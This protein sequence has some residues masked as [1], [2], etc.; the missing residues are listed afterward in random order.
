MGQTGHVFDLFDRGALQVNGGIIRLGSKG[1]AEFAAKA[2]EL[3]QDGPTAIPQSEAACKR[4]LQNYQNHEAQMKAKFGELAEE[5]TADTETQSRIVRELWKLFYAA[6][7]KGMHEHLNITG[8]P[9]KR[10]T[11]N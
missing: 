8:S 4:A 2:V 3:G 5:R 10:P 11:S 1:R 9:A 7:R 6:T